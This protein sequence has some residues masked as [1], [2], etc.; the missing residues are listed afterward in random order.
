MEAGKYADVLILDAN[1]L[2]DIRNTTK[3]HM[4]IQNGSILD[5][6][7]DGNFIDRIPRPTRPQEMED[8]TFNDAG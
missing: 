1:P 5:T 2:E 4:V 3:I 7:L 8:R 6:R